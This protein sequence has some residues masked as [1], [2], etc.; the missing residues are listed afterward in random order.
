MM[1]FLHE[2]TRSQ[3]N[4]AEYEAVVNE[5]I[6]QCTPHDSLADLG[7]SAIRSYSEEPTVSTQLSSEA[8]LLPLGQGEYDERIGLPLIVVCQNVHPPYFELIVGR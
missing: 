7:E 1:G 6:T 8:P 2:T 3:S 5:I 4:A